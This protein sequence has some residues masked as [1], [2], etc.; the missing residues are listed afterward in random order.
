MVKIGFVG[1]GGIAQAHLGRLQEMEEVQIAALCDVVEERVQEAVEK[2][3]GTPYTDYSRLLDEADIDALYVCVPPFAHEE[4]EVLAARRGVHLFVEKPV[5]MDLDQGLEILAEVEKAG[6]LSSVGYSLRYRPPWQ[7][8]RQLLQGRQVA[9]VAAN[10]WG[11]IPGDDNHWWR[12]YEKSGGQLVEM[13]TH[14]IDAM[15]WLVGD[16]ARVHARYGRQVTDDIANMT[17]P[18]A[19]VVNIEFTSGAVGY[20]STSCALTQGGGRSD[21]RVVL[22]DAVIEVAAEVSVSPAAALDLS[23]LP[24]EVQDIDAAFVEAVQSGQPGSILCDYR[25]G[26]KSA[27]VCLAANQSAAS[28][29]P[30]SCWRG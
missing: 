13:A 29:Q 23:E 14:Q 21:F 11:G 1:T 30:Q 4:A 19:Q 2:F 12:V 10:R 22:R 7:G 25:E 20:I 24:Q 27:A 17:I 9:L 5:V 16:I 28:G 8:A 26:L 3:G 18:D 6:I 15:R